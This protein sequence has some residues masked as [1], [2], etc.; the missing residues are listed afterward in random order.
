MRCVPTHPFEKR[1]AVAFAV[2]HQRETAQERVFAQ[3]LGSGLVGHFAQE[4]RHEVVA[5]G[6]EESAVDDLVD[7]EKGAAGLVVHP[8]VGGAPQAQPLA[9]DV[10]ARQLGFAAVIIPDVAIDLE[11]ADGFRFGLH[12]LP[13]QCGGVFFRGL[14]PAHRVEIFAQA[15]RLGHAVRMPS[16]V[17]RLARHG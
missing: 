4:P 8:V 2:E 3:W 5:Q 9:G 10:F 15:A 11:G 6:G 17:S 13:R 12:P 1:G 14:V 7:G 16:C